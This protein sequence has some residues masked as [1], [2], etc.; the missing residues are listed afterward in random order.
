[1]AYNNKIVLIGNLGQDPKILIFEKNNKKIKKA[2]F[3]IATSDDFKDSNGQWIPR[4]DWHNI[5]LWRDDAEMAE[6]HLV[7]GSKVYLE[8]KLKSRSYEKDGEKKYFY[9]V[10]GERILKIEKTINERELIDESVKEVTTE[11]SDISNIEAP[12][13]DLP[14]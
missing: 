5:E 11:T 12:K 6:K 3:S 4:T 7:K 2:S 14:F 10:E 8:G 13:D 9:Y 1:M